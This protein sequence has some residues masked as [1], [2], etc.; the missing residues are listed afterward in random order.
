MARSVRGA[1]LL[2]LLFLVGAVS[3]IPGVASAQSDTGPIMRLLKSGRLPKERL[4]NVVDLVCQRGNAEDL[5]YVFELVTKPDGL[6]ADVRLKALSGLTR[7][8]ETR[9]VQPAGDLTAL[10]TLMEDKDAAVRLAAVRL[11]GAWKVESLAPALAVVITSEASS[12]AKRQAAIHSVTQIGGA[13]AETLVGQLLNSPDV[14]SQ[15]LGVAT[16]AG[17]D[18]D[19]AA[20]KAADVLAKVQSMHQVGTLLNSFLAQQQG[21]EKLATA[22]AGK[23]LGQDAAKLALR[24]VYSVGR[25]D[26]ALVA[27]LSESAGIATD[28]PPLTP[29]VNNSSSPLRPRAIPS[30]VKKSFAVRT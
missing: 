5:A 20:P 21:S 6:P 22:L 23:A 8:A 1:S 4:G 12:P 3:L 14:S 9:K 30:A 17:S 19:E 25:S 10:A 13:A 7:A 18:I 28:R 11:A 29:Q 15:V 27:A 16:L 2:I 26:A 24:H